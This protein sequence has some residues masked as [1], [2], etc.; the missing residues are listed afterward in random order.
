M[1]P[2]SKKF[3][4]LLALTNQKLSKYRKI[5]LTHQNFFCARLVYFDSQKATY[6]LF[7]K[8][9]F[10]NNG[11]SV[12]EAEKAATQIVEKLSELKYDKKRGE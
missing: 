9:Y 8:K 10:I 6:R 7:V 4:F 3:V 2:L 11:V 12:D 5:L 1:I